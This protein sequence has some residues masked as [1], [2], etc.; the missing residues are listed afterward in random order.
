MLG[1]LGLEVLGPRPS[2]MPDSRPGR[3]V[4]ALGG[5]GDL[6]GAAPIA[7]VFGQVARWCR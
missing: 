1:G 6:P 7:P 4:G 3:L 5:A 2:T